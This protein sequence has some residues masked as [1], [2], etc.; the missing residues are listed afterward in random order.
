MSTADSQL[1]GFGNQFQSE[2]IAGALPVGRNSPQ[3]APLGLYAELLSGSAFTAPR[4]ENRRTWLYRRQPSVMAGAYTP[5][6]HAY[7]KTGAAE[8]E[9]APPDPMRWHHKFDTYDVQAVDSP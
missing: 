1:A 4:A 5:Y 9:V 6:P 3:R 7:W 2:A 8:G